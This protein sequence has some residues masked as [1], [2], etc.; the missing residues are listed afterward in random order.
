M[1]GF[2]I[3]LTIN[4]TRQTCDVLHEV[5]E[6][7]EYTLFPP[8]FG[9]T[10]LT[11]KPDP[12]GTP[13]RVLKP[14]VY[15]SCQNITISSDLIQTLHFDKYMLRNQPFRFFEINNTDSL[16]IPSKVFKDISFKFTELR[17]NGADF[18]KVE[19][20]AFEG[21]SSI[22]IL[23]LK[24]NNIESL[25]DVVFNLPQLE[26]LDL[27]LNNLASL[28]NETFHNFP[29]LKSL[30]LEFNELTYLNSFVFENLP[31]LETLRLNNN[32]L[33]N[34]PVNIFF[35][36]TKLRRIF[37]NTNYLTQ[38]T[39]LGLPA[40][41]FLD[42]SRNFI[43]TIDMKELTTILKL[44]LS[45]ND[46][47]SIESLFFNMLSIKELV[48]ESNGLR[49]IAKEAFYNLTS[50]ETI[51]LN[52]NLLEKLESN[53][54]ENNKN[55]TSIGMSENLF[56][57]IPTLPN[58]VQYF[59][60]SHNKLENS[61]NLSY[62]TRLN[63]LDMSYNKLHVIKFHSLA[64]LGSLRYLLLNDNE[65]KILEMGCF[66]DLRVLT[67]LDLSNNKITNFNIGIFTGINNL[68]RLNLSG[69]KLQVL[70]EGIFH[71]LQ[72]LY[73][74]SI[75]FNNISYVSVENTL[76]HLVSL[77]EL[78]LIG[79]NWSCDILTKIAKHNGYLTFKTAQNHTV[80]NVNGVA[81]V[82]KG[83]EEENVNRE[84]VDF[85]LY[86]QKWIDMSSQITTSNVLLSFILLILCLQ[87]CFKPV[88]KYFYDNRL[89]R[90]GLL[91]HYRAKN[92]DEDDMVRPY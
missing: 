54:F 57:A 87:F 45:G 80:T 26:E 55:L 31:K 56:T 2:L 29:D 91:L 39:D 7:T 85:S 38:L 28:N 84:K 36:N 86:L 68:E 6:Y 67:I 50:L 22:K 51:S 63:G 24:N 21:L 37:L 1:G 10:V 53:L 60:I 4:P 83:Q 59:N 46:I 66:K 35:N 5:E 27:S 32:N 20:D 62:L 19:P 42:C 40:I 25:D 90:N 9:R 52:N 13:Y 17:I 14:F 34:L 72:K 89:R 75:A 11:M 8:N 88:F 71:N 77:R 47:N 58:S 48:L 70:N 18:I 30:N 33:R 61:L 44:D 43:R 76:K 41:D 82:V 69:N 49:K 65:I 73:T 16:V 12:R 64:N 74:L 78:D 15:V 81:C 79:N 3:F 92:E 23:S